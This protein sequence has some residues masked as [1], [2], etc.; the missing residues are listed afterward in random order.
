MVK[1]QVW[2]QEVVVANEVSG[3]FVVFLFS[4]YLFVASRFVIV[5]WWRVKQF[6]YARYC[7]EPKRING[8]GRFPPLSTSPLK[9]IENRDLFFQL[10]EWLQEA[11]S[12][13]SLARKGSDWPL[14]QQINRHGGAKALFG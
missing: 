8:G 12:R 10:W 14:G 1:P 5:D 6:G 7:D 3:N 2:Q 11:E 9:Q 13:N 4:K